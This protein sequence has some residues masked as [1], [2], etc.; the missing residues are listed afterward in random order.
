LGFGPRPHELDAAAGNDERL[1]AIRA[2][3]GKKLEHRLK[4]H[5]GVEAL[6]L[7]MSG[8]RDPVFHD[9]LELCGG[10]SGMSG[11]HDFHR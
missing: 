3:E 6:G 8:C 4:D 9:L 11:H 10:H 1:V 5:L 7:G 2:Q